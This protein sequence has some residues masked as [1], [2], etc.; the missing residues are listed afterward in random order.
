[1]YR[2]SVV[3]RA[4][5][6]F[7]QKFFSR[8]QRKEGRR[9]QTTHRFASLSSR[10]HDPLRFITSHSQFSPEDEADD[11]MYDRNPSYEYHWEN[12]TYKLYL[13]GFLSND[14]DQ[15]KFEQLI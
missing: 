1:M 9:E 11:P 7:T 2:C 4:T 3:N 10:S 14:K 13:T 8:A 12:K 15:V 6:S 5:R